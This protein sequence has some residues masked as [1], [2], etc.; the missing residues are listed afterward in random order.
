MAEIVK[1]PVGAAQGNTEVLY[2]RKWRAG[3]ARR[4]PAFQPI[5]VGAHVIAEAAAC[6]GYFAKA[7]FAACPACRGGMS[8]GAQRR[9]GNMY[10]E[11]ALEL[12]GGGIVALRATQRS[13][14]AH[15]V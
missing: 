2:N 13:I 11:A 12:C 4:S 3:N 10:K 14:S 9:H 8:R 6:A 1:W 15:V 7:A 5:S